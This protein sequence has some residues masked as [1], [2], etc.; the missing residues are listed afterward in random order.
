MTMIT[1]SYLGETIEYSSLHACRSTLED[2]TATQELMQAVQSSGARVM[3]TGLWGDQILVDH[4]YLIDLLKSLKWHMIW[5]HLTETE[6]GN[7]VNPGYHKREFLK[8]VLRNWTPETLLRLTRKIRFRPIQ[9][10]WY[11]KDLRRLAYRHSN[12]TLPKSGSRHARA[13]YKEARSGYHTLTMEWTN[14]LACLYNLDVAF[15][16]FD[17]ELVR[18]LMAIPPEF[19]GSGGVPKGILRSAMQ[20]TLPEPIKARRDKADFTIRIN[21]GMQNDFAKLRPFLD[22]NNQSVQTGWVSPNISA[23]IEDIIKS[24]GEKSDALDAWAI[25]DWIGL[26]LWLRHFLTRATAN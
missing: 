15:P 24:I 6:R 11:A 2:P 17:R 20:Y 5:R 7:T 25:R 16:F 10:G 14:K 8:S 3:L 12:K 22:F 9:S 23:G 4:S 18:F 21:R 26:E 13:L 19:A 1:P